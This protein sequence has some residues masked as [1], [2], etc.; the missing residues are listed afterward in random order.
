MPWHGNRDVTLTSV[1]NSN[2]RDDDEARKKVLRIFGGLMAVALLLDVGGTVGAMGAHCMEIIHEQD[3]QQSMAS[4]VANQISQ[5]VQFWKIFQ[6]DDSKPSMMFAGV[7]DLFLLAIVRVVATIL[8]LWFGVH[9]GRYNKSGDDD[10]D[11]SNDH[12]QPNSTTDQQETQTISSGN[13]EASDTND[14]LTT[15]LLPNAADAPLSSLEAQAPPSGFRQCAGCCVDGQPMKPSTARHTALAGLFVTA[16]L[17]Q[18]YVGLKVSNYHHPSDDTDSANMR[19]CNDMLTLC[20]CLTVLWINL[21]GYLFRTL[22]AE[23]TREKGLFLANSVH[24]H[25]VFYKK[26]RELG[27]QQCDLCHQR[28]KS[29]DEGCYRCVLCDWDVCLPCSR[30]EDAATVGENVLR[31]DRGVRVETDMDSKSYF[32]RALHVASGETPLLLVSFILLAASS[33]SR[34]LLPHFQGHVIDKVIPD[35][36]TGN[37][38]KAGFRHYIKVYLVLMIVQGALSTLY[39]A[40]FTLVSRR[41]KFTIRN[42]LFE[43]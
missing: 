19:E 34:L 30:R 5:G 3:D 12:T 20:M 9:H 35:P 7:G 17:F 31:S 13:Q 36:T 28:I 41:L 24:R 6:N 43:R 18:V 8:L 1:L 25:P 26:F 4:C 14:A 33:M 15:P 22:L 40:I 21:Q 2:A 29:T 42:S 32:S 27:F 10:S 39:S 38:D 37:Y 23:M 11:A 16:T